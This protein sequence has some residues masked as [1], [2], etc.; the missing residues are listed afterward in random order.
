M[1]VDG[2]A[3]P[4][5]WSAARLIDIATIVMGQSP[6]SS[7]YNVRQLGLPF[8]QGKA[9]FGEV[10]AT[11]RVWCSNP[12]KTGERDDIL[13]SVRAPVGPTNLAPARCCIGRGLAAIR[14]EFSVNARYILYAFRR[15]ADD[16][17]SRGTGTTFKAV[18]GK[19]VREFPVPIA[20]ES[21]QDRIAEL[22]D[23]LFSDLDAGVAS[24]ER[25]REK[26][27][28]YRASVL[29][30]AVEGRLT[31]DWRAQH[32]ATEP[33]SELLDRILAERRRKW[34]EDQLA[35]F[36]GNGRVP[37]RN[38]QAKYDEPTPPESESLQPPPEGWS[39][40]TVDQ[41]SQLIQYG[42]SAKT[43]GDAKGI[44][45]LRMGNIRND[46]RLDLEGL[47]YLGSDHDEFPSL[48]LEPGDLLF[49]RTNSAE[50]VGKTALYRGI[51]NP[52]SFASYLIRVRCL[53]GVTPA[54][55]VFSLNG[56]LGRSWIRQVVNQ[57]VGQANVNG[58]K[59]ASFAF[60]LPPA[61]EQEVIVEAAEEQLS[62]ID[63]LETELE[64]KLASAQSLRQAILRH[65]FTGQ[66]VPQD[67]NDE[68]ASELLKRIAIERAATAAPPRRARRAAPARR[69]N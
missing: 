34:E 13:L 28:L 11:P 2:S 27:K 24:L 21:E 53:R 43:G 22:I 10:Y 41:C 68:P 64:A 65:A 62:I 49:N 39:W 36:E 40:A 9:D 66:L 58:T 16:L 31:E 1:S 56:G 12:G 3:L 23:E 47:K 33:A 5:G 6:P 19:V 45:V 14:P 20:P 67:P 59:L 69:R 35:K 8:F 63:H 51:P 26:L 18:S 17:D 38:W 25:V 32:P 44:P 42:T 7:T 15:F 61:A 37:P 55:V 60:P 4:M 50:L 46:G 52:C 30:A 29:K 54:I 48:Y 57:T